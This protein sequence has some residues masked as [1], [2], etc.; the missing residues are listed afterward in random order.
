MWK[1]WLKRILDIAGPKTF[2]V[3]F[4]TG[5]LSFCCGEALALKRVDLNLGE[6]FLK[7]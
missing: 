5:T 7:W 3:I 6:P 2:F 4:L 1:E